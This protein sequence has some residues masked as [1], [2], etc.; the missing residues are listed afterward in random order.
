MRKLIVT[1]NITRDAEVRHIP[2]GDSVINF[3]LAVNERWMVN[4]EKR[5]AVHYF[6]CARWG[7]KTDI[8]KYLL[9]GVKVL[10]EGTPEAEAYLNKDNVPIAV[11]KI[12]VEKIE[13]LAPAKKTDSQPSSAASTNDDPL[14]KPEDDLPF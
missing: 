2:S 8:V 7:A 11:Q 12:K 13:F 5:E 14:N 10:L 3:D 1:G 4:G 9:K 6:K